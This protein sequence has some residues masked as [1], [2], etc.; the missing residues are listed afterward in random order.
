MPTFALD[1]HIKEW[2]RYF[3]D[4]DSAEQAREKFE[5]S[6]DADEEFGYTLKEYE[7]EIGNI[8]EL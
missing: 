1:L 6:S 2:R 4:A 8:E 7:N 3:I 5:S